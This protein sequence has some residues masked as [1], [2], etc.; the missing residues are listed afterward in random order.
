MFIPTG[1]VIQRRFRARVALLRVPGIQRPGAVSL[2]LDV[3]GMK[4]LVHAHG[5][6]AEILG[7]QRDGDCVRAGKNGVEVFRLGL[8]D[9]DLI[10]LA[11]QFTQ[12]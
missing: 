12:E 11:A 6:P 8:H 2:V 3:S 10:L 9:A 4:K 5:R 1:V 7:D